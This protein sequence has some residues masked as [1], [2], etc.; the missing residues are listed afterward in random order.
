LVITLNVISLLT[1]LIMNFNRFHTSS[2]TV[3]L[4]DVLPTILI[5][6]HILIAVRTT[7]PIKIFIDDVLL[8]VLT[9]IHTINWINLVIILQYL[10]IF[11]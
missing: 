3:V 10:M 11:F 2:I 9:I 7:V 1:I 8:T 4:I 6:I 5:T